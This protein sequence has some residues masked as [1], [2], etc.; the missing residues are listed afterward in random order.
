MKT[1]LYAMT[2]ASAAAIGI[3]SAAFGVEDSF[4]KL[5]TNKDGKLSKA[6]AAGKKG[7]DFAK[8]DTNHDGSLDRAEYDAATR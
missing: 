4:D 8:A 6:E 5:D 2:L 3:A 7:L 1:F